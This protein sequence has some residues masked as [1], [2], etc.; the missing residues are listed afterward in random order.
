M[1]TQKH[2]GIDKHVKVRGRKAGK[3]LP[4]SSQNSLSLTHFDI[5]LVLAAPDSLD[6]LAII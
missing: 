3:L 1:H 6:S 5:Y 2:R 4:S